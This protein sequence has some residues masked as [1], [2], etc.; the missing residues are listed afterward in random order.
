[1][2][3]IRSSENPPRTDSR[4]SA[5]ME[6]R[7]ARSCIGTDTPMKISPDSV[8]SAGNTMTCTRC[9]TTKRWVRMPSALSPGQRGTYRCLPQVHEPEP[10]QRLH[11]A[12]IETL[13]PRCAW[14]DEAGESD[15]SAFLRPPHS[16]HGTGM[17]RRSHA[18][19][20][21]LRRCESRRTTGGQEEARPPEVPSAH[22][23]PPVRATTR[24]RTEKAREPMAEAA[25]RYRSPWRG[26]GLAT[27]SCES[28]SNLR[29][30][31]LNCDDHARKG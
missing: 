27:S 25:G 31:S 11:D 3:L 5:S 29:C 21:Y 13:K 17:A 10:W 2:P 28:Q 30:K 24:A 16:G 1:M 12:C 19:A 22:S 6:A 14:T 15:S 4:T 26:R 7:P 8:S 9:S 20:G 23:G 18:A